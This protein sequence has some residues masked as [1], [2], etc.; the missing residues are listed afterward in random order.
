MKGDGASK[1]TLASETATTEGHTSVSGADA[2][3]EGPVDQ[4]VFF[5]VTPNGAASGDSVEL[6]FTVVVGE[7]EYSL[8]SEVT[9]S[10]SPLTVKMP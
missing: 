4:R 6:Y 2:Y 7:N 3:V 10:Q 9:R 5:T 8:H 1:F